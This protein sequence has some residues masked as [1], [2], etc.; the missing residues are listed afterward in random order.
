MS[1]LFDNFSSA[2]VDQAKNA[3]GT[4]NIAK[5]R[6]IQFGSQGD[7]CYFWEDTNGNFNKNTFE[8]VSRRA[9]PGPDG[10]TGPVS[11]PD[12][13]PNAYDQVLRGL[14]W[15]L[16]KSDRDFIQRTQLAAQAQAGSLVKTWEQNLGTITPDQMKSADVTQKVNYVIEQVGA[17]W[18]GTQKANKPN[19]TYSNLAN[20]RDL[21]TL[22]PD[23]PASGVSVLPVLANY[24]GSLNPVL[25]L[26]DSQ[27][28]SQWLLRI[29]K[30]NLS[31]PNPKN[32]GMTTVDSK[33]ATAN[34]IGYSLDKTP[35]EI[36]NMLD[37]KSSL[38]ISMQAS[39]QS[40]R[41]TQVS[42][43]GSAAGV[44]P[45]EFLSI[46]IGGS[47]EYSLFEANGSGSS[48]SIEMEFPGITP[49]SIQPALFSQ[50]SARGWLFASLVA[51]AVDNTK[52]GKSGADGVTGWQFNEE[53]PFDFADEGS[54]GLLTGL[55]LSNYPT[56]RI[57]Y[58]AG[59]YS[60]FQKTFK[61]DASV[62]VSLFGIRLGGA[63]ESSFHQDV[64]ESSQSSQFTLTLTPPAPS[65][66][67]SP[68]D[69][70]AYVLGGTFSY[71]GDNSLEAQMAAALRITGGIQSNSMPDAREM[72]PA[73]SAY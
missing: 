1:S 72:T 6:P 8:Y 25:N 66:D 3:L 48:A 7:F 33:G 52:K 70:K 59:S 62:G 47:A 32:G 50:T 5:L 30:T 69:Q 2:I 64:Q 54:F 63:S 73:N 27:T 36:M 29:L 11:L 12:S 22:L 23:M 42:I 57:T 19:L 56:I 34:E 40:S 13:F 26:L 46:D 16:S 35:A 60:D 15:G 51:Q 37:A 41:V 4:T 21:T 44:L 43:G 55:I 58:S 28:N 24:L 71:P 67:V 20:A 65:V 45:F 9:V 17:L 68:L 31:T 39:Q 38:T 14:T 53:M 49:V 18:S 61:Q 10:A